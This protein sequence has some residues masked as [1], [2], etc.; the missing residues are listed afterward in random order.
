MRKFWW[1]A[2]RFH[3]SILLCFCGLL[4]EAEQKDF[5]YWGQAGTGCLLNYARVQRWWWWP[6]CSKGQSWVWYMHQTC[7]GT[8]LFLLV[9]SHLV[10]PVILQSKGYCYPRYEPL[11]LSEAEYLPK[12]TQL[13][14]SGSWDLSIRD[15]TAGFLPLTITL[16]WKLI[17]S[18]KWHLQQLD[19]IEVTFSDI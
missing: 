10:W 13:L 2:F 11:R 7:A 4:K 6:S 19:N 8:V 9:L 5:C 17:L 14:S 16:Y 3:C 18:F 12:V 1:R 15:L